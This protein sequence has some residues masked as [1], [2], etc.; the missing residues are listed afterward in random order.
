MRKILVLGTAVVSSAFF[1]ACEEEAIPVPLPPPPP[2]AQV[3]EDPVLPPPDDAVSEV[4]TP[5]S[6]D[7]PPPSSD[8]A[9]AFSW[10]T[11]DVN[12][13]KTGR[14][15][16]QIA[17]FPSEA[18]AKKLVKKMS[19]NGIRAYYAKVNNPAQLL[20]TY[21]RVRIGYFNGKSVAETFAKTRLEPLGY[22]WYVDRGKNDTLGNPM[23]PAESKPVNSELE[24]AKKAYK[25]LA[26]EAAKE[27]AKETAK[28]AAKAAAARNP[29]APPPVK[30][31][32]T[33][34]A[35][36]EAAKETAKEAAKAAAARNPTAPPPVKQ[37]V[38]P[39]KVDPVKEATK[40]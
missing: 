37:E 18:S 16:I 28:E 1:F 40:K 9:P 6:S 2:A 5:P 8:P 26:K 32:V 25:E 3:A 23:A 7:F 34:E 38:A 22:A 14:Y 36:K 13:E 29:T 21:Y 10:A 27:A 11:A 30:Q 33:K 31:E 19:D 24:E 12:Q 20:G 15:T 39:P 35:A 17:V 4:A